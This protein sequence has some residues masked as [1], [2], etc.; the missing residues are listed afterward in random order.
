ML[1]EWVGK[2]KDKLQEKSGEKVD[3]LKF[4][5]CCTFDIMADLTFSECEHHR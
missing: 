5:N 2:L 1:K 3:L 4:Y